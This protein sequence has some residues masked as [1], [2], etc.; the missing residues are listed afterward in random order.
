MNTP[1]ASVA[2]VDVIA[3]WYA[4]EIG[5]EALFWHL[6][7]A[8][9]PGP[10]PKWLALAALE[11]RL[12]EHLLYVLLADGVAVPATAASLDRARMR[13]AAVAPRPWPGQMAWLEELAR[14]ALATMQRAAAVLPDRFAATGALVVRHEAALLE[15]A[16]R[17]LAGDAAGSLDPIEAFLATTAR[18]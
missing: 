17:E 7:E 1:S 2:A 18:P 14:D 13:A 6:A 11:A 10:A 8:A 5:G 4:G 9:G 12:A 16:R 15:F 3:D